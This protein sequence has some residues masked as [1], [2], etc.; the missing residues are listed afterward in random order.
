[1]KPSSNL[2]KS[3][4]G[5]RRFRER[6]NSGA[7]ARGTF[8]DASVQS[9]KPKADVVIPKFEGSDEVIVRRGKR[10]RVVAPNGR[11]F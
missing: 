7:R 8:M 9:A 1:M 4:D 10:R 11:T 3:E 2:H 6:A 5:W